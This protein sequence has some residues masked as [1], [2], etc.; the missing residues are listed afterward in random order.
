MIHLRISRRH[1]V[2]RS[3]KVLHLATARI[4]HAGAAAD[5]AEVEAKHGAADSSQRF[6]RV[7]DGFRVHR[8]SSGR[9]RMSEYRDGADGVIEVHI[10]QPFERSGWS[11][12]L[13]VYDADV[14]G[15]F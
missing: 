7:E 15:H 10:D 6:G 8:S 3:G 13:D 5:T 11:R 4:E 14:A 9:Q 2:D 12:N 1:E